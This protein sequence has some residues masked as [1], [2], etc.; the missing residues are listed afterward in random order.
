MGGARVDRPTDQRFC[1]FGEWVFDTTTGLL[2]GAGRV[3]VLQPL[4]ASLL[5][6]L[7]RAVD[8]DDPAERRVV[9]YDELRVAVWDQ[10]SVTEDS[11]YNTVR[12]VRRA[13]GTGLVENMSRRGYRFVG[14]RPAW[15]AT[16]E[17]DSAPT[18]DAPEDRTSPP[19][20]RE[21][22][23][24]APHPRPWRALFTTVGGI[25]LLALATLAATVV[26][27]LSLASPASSTAVVFVP[28]TDRSPGKTPVDRGGSLLVGRDV[29]DLVFQRVSQHLELVA[30]RRLIEGC[31]WLALFVPDFPDDMLVSPPRKA[32]FAYP[33]PLPEVHDG[34]D[35]SLRLAE[36]KPL[37]APATTSR[38]GNHP[39][40]WL[41]GLIVRRPVQRTVSCTLTVK[42]ASSFRVALRV[43][44]A[45]GVS[46]LALSSEGS[47]EQD[48]IDGAATQLVDN[49]FPLHAAL[50]RF[51]AAFERSRTPD[52]VPLRSQAIDPLTDPKPFFP[53]LV[54]LDTMTNSATFET[55]RFAWELQGLVYLHGLRDPERAE[56]SFDHAQ[57]WNERVPA[58][59]ATPRYRD[60][61]QLERALAAYARRDWDGALRRLDEALPPDGLATTGTPARSWFCQ[62]KALALLRQ[63]RE[64]HGGAEADRHDERAHHALADCLGNERRN[65]FNIQRLALS[66]LEFLRGSRAAAGSHDRD[67]LALAVDDADALVREYPDDYNLQLWRERVHRLSGIGGAVTETLRFP[68][69]VALMNETATTLVAAGRIADAIAVAD[70]AAAAFNNEVRWLQ[71]MRP[72]IAAALWPRRTDPSA[73]ALEPLRRAGTHAAAGSVTPAAPPLL[74]LDEG[75]D[76]EREEIDLR[77]VRARILRCVGDDERAAREI[78]RAQAAAVAARAQVS[79]PCRGADVQA[80]LERLACPASTNPE[81][82]ASVRDRMRPPHPVAREFSN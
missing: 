9:T 22:D 65:V 36:P 13:V 59:S 82:L 23:S 51:N 38:D 46:E 18:T 5:T 39:V 56:T 50:V 58:D 45:E 20:F 72:G 6:T 21:S 80:C 40:A 62:L 29:T 25:G 35:E 77:I 30:R 31:D 41:A 1:A 81:P 57:A 75:L 60:D 43:L 49:L 78:E 52:C 76:P 53:L 27:V 24:S 17:I 66:Q 44:N 4:P 8:A 69:H 19:A 67:L 71:D 28:A 63:G 70:R 54:Q 3:V 68:K 33:L 61:L 11:F 7:L 16:P 73:G 47:T 32:A 34:P 74:S 64:E 55:R 48:A 10:D 14:P 12:L 26:L 2:R 37:L 42:S 79:P 15:R